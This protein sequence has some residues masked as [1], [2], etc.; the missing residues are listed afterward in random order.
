MA[1]DGRGRSGRRS[2]MRG[3]ECAPRDGRDNPAAPAAVVHR[4]L[5]QA[6]EPE[7]PPEVGVEDGAGD[8]DPE[9]PESVEADDE[10]ESEDDEPDEAAGTVED[11]PE[12][13]SV[14]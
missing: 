1:R 2:V 6:A 4:R 14:R 7:V 3:R 12:R 8:D 11:E 10:P 5:G 13:L 9:E